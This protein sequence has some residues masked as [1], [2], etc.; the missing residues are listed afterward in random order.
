MIRRDSISSSEPATYLLLPTNQIIAIITYWPSL[1]MLSHSDTS[2]E[3][4]S[5]V[6]KS[7]TDIEEN[8]LDIHDSSAAANNSTTS[9]QNNKLL[10]AIIT[11]ITAGFVAIGA[12][13]LVLAAFS[14]HQVSVPSA[15]S[16]SL[17]SN[18]TQYGGYGIEESSS[19][20]ILSSNHN[21]DNFTQANEDGVIYEKTGVSAIVNEQ[22][23]SNHNFP[24][25]NEEDV[26][27]EKT[28]ASAIVNDEYKLIY[29]HIGKIASTEFKRFMKRMNND[30]T[31]CANDEFLVHRIGSN[32]L[33]YLAYDYSLKEVEHMMTSDE[34]TKAIFVRDPKPR[35][36]SGFLD[37]AVQHKK[38]F[39]KG[40]CQSWKH[41]KD[42]DDAQYCYDHRKDFSFFLHDI[43]KLNPDDLHFRPVDS[44]VDKKWWPYINFIGYMDSLSAD[45]KQLFKNIKS[46]V[47]DSSAWDRAGRTDWSPKSGCDNDDN[48]EF[49]QE[50]DS[51]H[52][53]G[54]REHMQQYYTDELEKFVETNWASDYENKFINFPEIKLFH[55]DD[56]GGNENDRKL[57]DDGR[58]WWS[59]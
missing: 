5:L 43:T 30:P 12:L 4:Y 45:S 35:L 6:D 34:W 41:K 13:L 54:A 40:Y 57:V 44:F 59:I 3:R 27:Y 31:W 25:A 32:G 19:A 58:D 22:I 56:E 52:K 29:F 36:L 51:H 42:A 18:S 23:S 46:I 7:E 33:K 53:T 2:N 11:T 21:V 14:A 39:E 10:I 47:D 24:E 28:A 38:K 8:D 48:E 1:I 9:T 15:P 55:H 17:Y 26:I 16:S 49:L 20:D 50:R 37:K